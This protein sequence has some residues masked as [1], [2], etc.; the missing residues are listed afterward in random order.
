M[1]IKSYL[2]QLVEKITGRKCTRCRHNCAGR[3]CHPVG[4]MFMRCWHSIT[5]PGFEMRPARYLKTGTDLNKVQKTGRYVS[6]A[7][8]ENS[9]LPAPLTPEEEYQLQK[10]RAALEEAG[11]TARE[12]GLLED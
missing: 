4:R 2:S 12:S 5:R 6:E 10:I 8:R 7:G 3:C 9:T 1:F 11:A